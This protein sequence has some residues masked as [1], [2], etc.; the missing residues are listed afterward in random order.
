VETALNGQVAF[1][2][3]AQRS[4]DVILSD[5]K[6]PVLDG[7][8]LYRKVEAHYPALKGRFVFI[9]GDMVGTEARAFLERVGK[10]SLGKPFDFAAVRQAVRAVDRR[11]PSTTTSHSRPP[12]CDTARDALSRLAPK[13]G[14][15]HRAAGRATARRMRAG[16]RGPENSASTA[17]NPGN[18]NDASS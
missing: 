8:G 10:T 3:L 13:P 17:G 9:T 12:R 4:Y 2:K 6:M 15:R 1:D 5:I 14:G 16:E 18:P 7:P 11:F